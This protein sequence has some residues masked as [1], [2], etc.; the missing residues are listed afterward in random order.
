[1]GCSSA[2]LQAQGPFQPYG[3]AIN[4]LQ[5]GASF[6]VGN[7]WDVTD[8]DIDRYTMKL[9]ETMGI[10]E[11][12]A[13]AAASAADGQGVSQISNELKRMSISSSANTQDNA[14][15]KDLLSISKCIALSRDACQLKYL[16]GAA[17]VVY[18][19]PCRRKLAG[20]D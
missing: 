6:V 4:Y 3:T 8:K 12:E 5:G 10:R 1:M 20:V 17:P 2:Q 7:L 9:F 11:K 14:T 15:P 19:L 13:D 16:I 18:G